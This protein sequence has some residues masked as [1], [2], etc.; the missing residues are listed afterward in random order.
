MNRITDKNEQDQII[1]SARMFYHLYGNIFRELG[2]QHT[3]PQ[4]A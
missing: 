3:L 4:V 2:G 1:R